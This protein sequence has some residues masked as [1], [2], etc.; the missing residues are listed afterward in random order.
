MAGVPKHSLD[1][2]SFTCCPRWDVKVSVVWMRWPEHKVPEHLQPLHTWHLVHAGDEREESRGTHQCPGNSH[3][4]VSWSCWRQ[5]FWINCSKLES[6][7]WEGARDSG[8]N[9]WHTA[10]QSMCLF[11]AADLS[12]DVHSSRT[13]K[14]AAK[15]H[16]KSNT[17]SSAL[18][19]ETAI[20]C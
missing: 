7:G 16:R 11:R 17:W 3:G 14:T 4:C 1:S 15:R 8:L 13:L 20:C 19:S 9:G 5:T 12:V 18:L 6:Q 10:D 2:N